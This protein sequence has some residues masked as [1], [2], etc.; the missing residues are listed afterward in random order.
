MSL[1][2]STP[3]LMRT[4]TSKVC[5]RVA[6]R[7]DLGRDFYGQQPRSG[8]RVLWVPDGTSPEDVL[9]ICHARYLASR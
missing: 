3:V 2:Y 7:E 8:V 9:D 4:T 6:W 5:Y 1:I